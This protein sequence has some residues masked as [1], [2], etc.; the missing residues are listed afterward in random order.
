MNQI[1]ALVLAVGG[2]VFLS[3]G[4]ALQWL[5]HERN[6]K[7]SRLGWRVF[8]EPLWLGG[9]AASAIGTGL[10]YGALWNGL[11]A[12]V[13]PVS[14]LHIVFTVVAMGRLNKEAIQG[15]RAG[16]ILLVAAG[17]VICTLVEA[18]I[19]GVDRFD[20]QGLAVIAAVSLSVMLLGWIFLRAQVF[21]MGAG[22]CYALSALAMK[23]GSIHSTI[24]PWAWM[25]VFLISYV[26]GFLCFQAGFRRGGAGMVN[27]VATGVSTAIALL[28][29]VWMLGEPVKAL[30]WVG[31]ALIAGGVVLSGA[32]RRPE[33]SRIPGGAYGS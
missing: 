7:K 26:G 30:T 27:A 4:C 15:L 13:L 10:H 22:V 18:G 16:G 19:E 3:V 28:G 11:L 12:L 31:A 14:S 21:P 5:G 25:A 32:D 6:Q 8:L 17:V 23:L 24:P 2:A 33:E 1:L 9:I 20:P 29:A